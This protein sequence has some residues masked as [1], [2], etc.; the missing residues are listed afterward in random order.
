MYSDS[1][2]EEIKK[3]AIADYLIE[4]NDMLKNRWI[5]CSER[6]PN[7]SKCIVT[8]KYDMEV[9][10]PVYQTEN[11]YVEK[12]QDGYRFMDDQGTDITC[13]VI[14]WQPLPEPY[15]AGKLELE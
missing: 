9:G 7:V 4:H 11:A 12:C 8:V 14:A 13:N 5:P 3:K 1:E 10:P 2:I 15:K 6:L